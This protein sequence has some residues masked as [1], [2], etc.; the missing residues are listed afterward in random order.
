MFRFIR[1]SVV[2]LIASGALAQDSLK[3]GDP[4]CKGS[5]RLFADRTYFQL[6]HS[7]DLREPLWVGYVVTKADLDGSAERPSGFK[8]DNWMP[9]GGSTGA[10]QF[11]NTTTGQVMLCAAF[12]VIVENADQ[13]VGTPVGS[14]V[15]QGSAGVA[16]AISP[17]ALVIR[18][19]Q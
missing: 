1:F 6:C 2:I 19:S 13:P 14:C 15:I 16:G 8:E 11:I 12:A 3:Y 7:S 5:D 18:V 9:V 17:P 10:P 4:G